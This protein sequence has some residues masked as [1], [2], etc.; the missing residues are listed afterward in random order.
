MP[1]E[2]YLV[3]HS[4][5]QFE[6]ADFVIVSASSQSEATEKFF[7]QVEI[8]S[9]GLLEHFYS[10][11]MNASFA[12]EFWLQT[13]DEDDREQFDELVR[14]FFGEH[15]DFAETYLDFYWNDDSDWREHADRGT[16]S[17]EMLFYMV[18]NY[19]WTKLTVI[20]FKEIEQIC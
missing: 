5:S 13:A 17:D 16:F 19:S 10:R 9:S 7:R 12:E 2:Q 6:E 1:S 15:Q 3:G 11:A 18:S 20:P 14:E 8:K 4:D